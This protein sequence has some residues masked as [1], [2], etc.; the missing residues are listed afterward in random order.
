MSPLLEPL[1]DDQAKLLNFV[2][3]PFRDDCRWPTFSYVEFNMRKLGV[4]ALSV[5]RGL[6]TI[7]RAYGGYRAVMS[8]VAGDRPASDSDP[9]CARSTILT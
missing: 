3:T 2:W 5:L 6:P 7:G 4:N 9:C 1:E 8:S